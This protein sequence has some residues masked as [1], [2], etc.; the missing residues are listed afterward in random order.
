MPFY[1]GK[2]ITFDVVPSQLKIVVEHTSVALKVT[3]NCKL[4]TSPKTLWWIFV[5][6][7]KNAVTHFN[8][9]FCVQCTCKIQLWCR[10]STCW[11]DA[12][13]CEQMITNV[14]RGSSRTEIA[15]VIT[16]MAMLNRYY[17][18]ALVYARFAVLSR[19]TSRARWWDGQ[20]KP[21]RLG[22]LGACSW[23][24]LTSV[25]LTNDMIGKK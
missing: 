23:C 9:L 7:L 25:V 10:W 17:L 24:Q 1:K 11:R 2:H 18:Q 3:F 14:S 13:V 16:L 15:Y 21:H 12:C 6:T 22:G 8:M 20:G 5:S 19:L 4:L